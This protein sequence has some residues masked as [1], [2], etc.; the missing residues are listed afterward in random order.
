MTKSLAGSS[1]AHHA[2]AGI[3][4]AQTG[5]AINLALAVAKIA[6]GIAG[7]TYALIADGVESLADVA[8]SLIVWGGIAV[9]ARPPDED[10]PYGHG[11]A[12]ALAAVT[13]SLMLIAAGVGIA[14]Q[15][16]S[17][18]RTP[19]EFPAPWTLI[20]LLSVVAI[21]AL[22][23]SRVAVVGRE[24]N[25]TAV[26]ADARHHLS[27]AI[28]SLAAFIGISAALIG[29]RAGGSGAWAAADD[30]AA[31]VAALVI[32]W[33][34]ASM[35]LVGLNDLM[36]RS[37]GEGVLGPLRDVAARVPGVLAIETLTARRAGNGY[38]VT[39]HVQSDPR[40]T[41]ADGHALG[42]R[43]KHALMSSGKWVH[44]VHVHMEPFEP[45][46]VRPAAAAAAPAEGPPAR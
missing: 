29:R 23:A 34:G 6:A 1:S 19:H 32:G 26:A 35:F 33:N 9:G 28:T 38:R 12:E 7:H 4:A 3:R 21:K 43:V 18:I 20:V 8:A 40:M 39:I 27:D 5:V 41:L 25:S 36:D 37:P 11:K 30:W 16:L 13:V 15:A 44:A 24:S 2:R 22:L 46:A 45:D 42:G 10:H 17:E 31:L 14:I